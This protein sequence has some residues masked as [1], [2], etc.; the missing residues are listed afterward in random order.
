VEAMI[1]VFDRLGD[2]LGQSNAPFHVT[3][4]EPVFTS[5]EAARVRGHISGKWCEGIDL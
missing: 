5:E 4:H 1:S 3:R 2:L